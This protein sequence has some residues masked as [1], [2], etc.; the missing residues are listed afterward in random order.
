[1]DSFVNGDVYGTTITRVVDLRNFKKIPMYQPLFLCLADPLAK[2]R[3]VSHLVRFEMTTC[4]EVTEI[5][6]LH[7]HELTPWQITDW[8]DLLD[9][10]IYY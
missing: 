6:T 10:I 2:E 7:K 9:G 1:M 3:K 4:R 8:D 5:G